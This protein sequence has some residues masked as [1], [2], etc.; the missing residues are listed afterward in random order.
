MRYID[1]VRLEQRVEQTWRARAAMALVELRAAATAED[2][3]RVISRHARLWTEIKHVLSEASSGKCWYCESR[4]TRSDTAVDHF[5]PKNKV[6]D[7]PSHEGYWWLAFDFMNYRYCCTYCNST[8]SDR[9]RDSKGGKQ[10]QF[11]LLNPEERVFEEGNCDRERPVLLDPTRAAD[12]ILLYYREDGE[13]EARFRGD[14]A[15]EK[16]LRASQSI[17]IY[18]LRHTALVEARL[19]TLNRVRELVNLGKAYYDSWLNDGS[20][21]AAFDHVVAQLKRHC[22][23]DAEY[24]AAV[25]DFIKGFRDDSHPWIDNVF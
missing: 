18:H 17:E 4:E 13:P 15:S 3:S 6:D 1:L 24:S 22:A 23:G 8:R 7:C 9:S 16:A 10:S 5:R 25:V 14:T 19:E 21:P 11:P 20:D 2:R 12:T